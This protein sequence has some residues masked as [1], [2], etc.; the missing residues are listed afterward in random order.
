MS[1]QSGEKS[2]EPTE[3]KKRD[4]AQKGDVLRSKE[5]GTAVA[6][7]CGALWLIVG[8][9][10]L[11][12]MLQHTAR[13]AFQFERGTIDDFTPGQQ[14]YDAALAVL[15]PVFTLGLVVLVATTVSQ[16]G[17][18]E[19]RFLGSNLAPKGS[20][21]NPLSGLKRMFG[22]QGWIELAKSIAK[23]GL[24]G[25][26]GWWW[27]RGNLDTL[28]S[29]GRGELTGQLTAAWDAIATL[30][31]LLAV[32]L[33]IIALV[34]YPIQLFRRIARL[35]MTQQEV[36]D[37]NKQTEGAPEKKMAIRQRQRQLARGGVAKAM[38]EA[39]FV[40]TNP[41]HFSVAMTY[42]PAL[43]PAPVVLAKGRG[44]K[45][46]AMRELAAEM[47]VPMLEY[48]ALTRSVYFTTREN[49]VIREELFAAIASVL[50]F[51]MSLKRGEKPVRPQIS[52]PVELQFDAEGQ[53]FTPAR[54][55]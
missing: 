4:A 21:I 23:L 2:F 16:L 49:Q 43:A 42:D 31:V 32:G 45:A 34:D 18:G 44:D 7:L 33:A 19:G 41:T 22:A 24:L 55:A 28:L 9:P 39:Q 5:V 48:P 38:G 13:S 17:L 15:P 52:V 51:V 25:A 47:N 54:R 27:G 10:W 3:K 50:A 29:L 35:R 37:E 12:Q 20:R 1:E 40:L 30:L 6:I 11:L 46:M 53:A 26:I 8:G 14:I 36:R